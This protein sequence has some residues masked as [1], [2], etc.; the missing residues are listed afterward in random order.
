MP[1][2]AA[3]AS[4]KVTVYVFHASAAIV[5]ESLP[6]FVRQE[7][8]G[9]LPLRGYTWFQCTPGTYDVAVGD[10]TI[11][12]RMLATATLSAAAGET[13]YLKYVLNPRPNEF[14]LVG[15]F[16]GDVFSGKQ[17]SKPDSLIRIRPEE[18]AKLIGSY[19][20]VG[21]TYAPQEEPNAVQEPTAAST[22]DRA[23]EHS[24]PA[25]VGA[26]H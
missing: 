2:T 7:R 21:N 20:L 19:Q 17:V 11:A 22:T 26:Q 4:D 8:I 14:A 13:I 10:A 1:A 6:L 16:L 3:P 9:A 15:G 24:A 12:H 5:S 25:P 18:A 23:S